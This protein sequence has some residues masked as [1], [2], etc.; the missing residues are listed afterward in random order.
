MGGGGGWG[1]SCKIWELEDRRKLA[2]FCF[3][4]LGKV[5]QER[6]CLGIVPNVSTK[7]GLP[8]ETGNRLIS[9]GDRS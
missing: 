7:L 5:H 2:R 8:E 1:L 3:L 9:S 4:A 6:Y